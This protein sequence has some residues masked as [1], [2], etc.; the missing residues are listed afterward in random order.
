MSE[1]IGN[2]S[3]S[4][5]PG[6]ATAAG[7]KQLLAQL[8]AMLDHNREASTTATTLED[9][10]ARLE[11][12][13]DDLGTRVS[14]VGSPRAAT[15]ISEEFLGEK[16]KTLISSVLVESGFLEKFVKSTVERT[17]EQ[18]GGAVA[19]ED[20]RKQAARLAKEFLSENLGAV[21]QQQIQDVV[22]T[23]VGSFLA[24]EDMKVLLDDKFRAVTL[25]LKT[26]V[27]PNAVRHALKSNAAQRT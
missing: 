23:E 13:L 27:I 3:E 25:Y 1:N 16:L 10:L 24:G 5:S 21:F 6:F 9:R 20:V 4:S 12:S 15:G 19:N 2:T 14:D 17:L 7:P 8:A 26:D 22:R 11:T 18:N